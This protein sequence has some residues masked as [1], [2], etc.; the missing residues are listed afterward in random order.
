ML[1]VR[2]NAG[3]RNNR[4]DQ[5]NCRQRYCFYKNSFR[6]VQ[7]FLDW[8]LN[9]KCTYLLTRS[10]NINYETK[11]TTKKQRTHRN[12]EQIIGAGAMYTLL[13]TV[14]NFK[15]WKSLLEYL[16][17]NA[18]SSGNS[19]HLRGFSFKNFPGKHVKK[20]VILSEWQNRESPVSTI[21]NQKITIQTYLGYK[22][23]IKINHLIN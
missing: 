12:W 5:F 21:S 22:W 10:S 23:K 13:R 11:Q 15:F 3:E 18:L 2:I 14:A 8:F 19:Y 4:L 9:C 6:L 1:L 16:G 20:I 7:S 17:R